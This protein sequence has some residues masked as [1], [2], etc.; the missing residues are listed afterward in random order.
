VTLEKAEIMENTPSVDMINAYSATRVKHQ[1]YLID[2]LREE[3]FAL[4]P[5]SPQTECRSR[6]LPVRPGGR[7]KRRGPQCSCHFMLPSLSETSGGCQGQG[8]HA[9]VGWWFEGIPYSL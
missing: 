5:G 9:G 4:L 3:A 6:C 7:W 2:K 8:S 1:V